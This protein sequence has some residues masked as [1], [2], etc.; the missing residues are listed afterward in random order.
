M[1][2]QARGGSIVGQAMRE[3]GDRYRLTMTPSSA[4]ESTS[5]PM[6]PLS[7]RWWT[8]GRGLAGIAQ[9]PNPAIAVW[10]IASIVRWVGV[11]GNPRG[12][13]LAAGIA[14]GALLAWAADELLRGVSPI[15]RIMGF[16]VLVV[17]AM[18]LFA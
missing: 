2:G 8:G 7:I 18:R 12:E 9:A 6:R 15:R 16:V 13:T 1:S 14:V 17:L 3:R 5:G 4:D 11:P 10:A